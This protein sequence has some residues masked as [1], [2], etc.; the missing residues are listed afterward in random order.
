MSPRPILV[1]TL[2]LAVSGG[3]LPAQPAPSSSRAEL[4]GLRS[5]LERALGRAVGAALLPLGPA[6]SHA[7]RL[8]GYGAVIVLSPRPLA[9]RR[10]VRQ[11]LRGEAARR[12]EVARA[13]AQASRELAQNLVQLQEQGLAQV[14]LQV[15]DVGDLEREMEQQM[16]AQAEAM[17]QFEVDQQEWTQQREEILRRQ[18][19]MVEEQAEAFRQA[20]ERARLDAERSVRQR[21][22]PRAPRVIVAPEAPE[23]PE[24]PETLEA[25]VAPPMPGAPPAPAAPVAATPP[26]AAAPAALVPPV[27]PFPPEA[28]APPPP[29]W[30][31]W[32]DVSS[33]DED[34]EPPAP[35]SVI[36]AARDALAA[37]LESY[38][39]PIVSLG[40]DELVSVAVDFVPARMARARAA[41][42]VLARVHVRDLNDRL[43]GRLSAADLRRRIEYDEE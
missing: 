16:A 21:L 27:P 23:T 25:P 32:F 6:A 37:G 7:Y 8:K 36:A 38:A 9:E 29:P 34:A 19:R 42:T 22:V 35:A 39:R 33:E 31:F 41:R 5:A 11:V 2:L 14:E 3:D 17:R 28:A 15:V 13:L 1:A 4:E 20:A 40:P 12:Q 26:V 24:T 10:V 18:I 43:A 30:R